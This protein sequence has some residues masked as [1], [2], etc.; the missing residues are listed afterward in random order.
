MY[1]PDRKV[2]LLTGSRDSLLATIDP[3]TLAD[4]GLE[5][6]DTSA[7]ASLHAPLRL[8][9][10]RQ[11][12]VHEA[13]LDDPLMAE[14]LATMALDG[15]QVVRLADYYERRQ[16]RVLL[17]A[18]D[19]SWFLF[20][21]PLRPRPAYSAVKRSMD[22]VAG[23]LGSLIVLL[24]IPVLWC[25]VRWDD[26]GPLF[27]RQERVGLNGKTFT[28]WKFRTMRVD[29]EAGGPAWQVRTTRASPASGDYCDAPASTRSRSSSTCSRA[30]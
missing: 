8:P 27:F 3:A 10:Q 25:A 17:D 30:T 26:G 4:I 6:V 18:V 22:L 14:Q 7:A 16:R 13:A 19:E 28:I 15:L 29:A 21:R 11:V 12:V 23:L 1:R 20:D 9:R 5:V 2:G 24:A